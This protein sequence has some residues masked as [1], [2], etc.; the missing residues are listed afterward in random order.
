MAVDFCG[1]QLPETASVG[2]ARL[3]RLLPREQQDELIREFMFWQDVGARPLPLV[4]GGKFPGPGWRQASSPTVDQFID[5][6]R[7]NETHGIGVP[8]DESDVVIDIEGRARHLLPLVME[9]ASR[10]GDLPLLRRVVA[11]LTE[12]TPTGGLHIHARL[13]DAESRKQILARRP[14][15]DGPEML[16]EALGFGQQVVV[17]PSGGSTHSTG[18]PY[19]RLCGS[20]CDIVTL[21]AVEMARLFRP[22]RRLD[23]QAPATGTTTAAPRKPETVIERDFNR[24]ATWEEILEPRGWRKA[25]RG[26]PGRLHEIQTWTRPGKRS[27]PS[28]TTCGSRLCVFSTATDLPAF[29]PPTVQGGW[30][31]NSLTKF[32]AFARLHHNGDRRAAMQAARRM[33]YGE[34]PSQRPLPPASGDI[35]FLADCLCSALRSGPME[36][37]AICGVAAAA[38]SDDAL[39]RIVNRD[40]R[41]TGRPPVKAVGATSR[42]WACE[43]LSRRAIAVL[44][45]Q[46]KVHFDERRWILQQR[47]ELNDA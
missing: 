17:A 9:A 44:V 30:G 46:G 13:G 34:S 12:E 22:F 14:G 47:M 40:R 5:L 15:A 35:P 24:R 36:K 20:P 25:G 1:L 26:R 18:R 45:H 4:L 38:M 31:E 7:N 6:V 39:L 16:V 21:S 19:R 3:E 23:V 28:A 27:G 37:Q 2:E 41:G 10:S 29:E 11:G 32:E 42:L 33:G 8:L 43:R